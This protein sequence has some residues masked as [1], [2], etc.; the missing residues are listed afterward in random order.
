[1][2]KFSIRFLIFYEMMFGRGNYR[3]TKENTWGRTEENGQLN[4]EDTLNRETMR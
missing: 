3:G 1:M 4:T 2:V